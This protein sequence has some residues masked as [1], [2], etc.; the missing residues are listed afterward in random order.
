M[1]LA[2]DESAQSGISLLEEEQASKPAYMRLFQR[3]MTF[4]ASPKGITVG[5]GLVAILVLSLLLSKDY[6]VVHQLMDDEISSQTVY[7]PHEMAVLDEKETNRR[8]EQARESITP[9]Y[10]PEQ[11]LNQEIRAN[12]SQFFQQL[13][14]LA[15]QSALADATR[16][17]EFFNLTEQTPDAR[18]AYHFLF[19]S[20]RGA[21][22]VDAL[23]AIVRET[24]DRILAQGVTTS[25]YFDRRTELIQSALPKG[26]P[27]D[28]AVAAR[29]LVRQVI[30]PNRVL[31]EAAMRKAGSLAASKVQA[32]VRI[33]RKGEK[34]TDRGELITS[35]QS[36][37]LQQLGRSSQGINWLACLGVVMLT[38]IGIGTVWTALY[39][40]DNKA[41][42]KPSYAGMLLLIMVGTAVIFKVFHEKQEIFSPYALP[43]AAFAFTIAIFVQYRFAILATAVLVF[44]L[45]LTLKTDIDVLVMLMAGSLVGVFA[46]SRRVNTGERGEVMMAGV[47]AC[48]AQALL[49]AALN[50]LR[51]GS[52]GAG[53]SSGELLTLVGLGALG[54]ILSG[55]LTMGMLPYLETVF[56]L[57]TPYSI[58]ELGNH[59]KPLLKRMQFEAPGSLMIAS[60]AE[61]AAE[62]IGAN[63]LLARVGSLYHDIGKMKRPLFFIENQAYFGVENPHDKL[64]P[65]LSKM[66]VTAHPRDSLEMARQHGIPEVLQKFMTEHHG[67]LLAGYFYNKACME[68]GAENVNK[69]QFR[70]PGPKPNIKETAIVMLADAC[71]SA[72]RALKSPTPQQIEERIDKIIQQRIEDGQF[73]ECPI[74]FKEIK[75]VRD[76]FA[77]VLRGIQ[78]NRIEYQQ[79]VMR[80]LGRKIPQLDSA[81]LEAQVQAQA[82]EGET[83]SEKAKE[84]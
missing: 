45:G 67:T 48:L 57:V 31:D 62:A 37:A 5:L 29:F 20:G 6:W 18:A 47:Y 16:R 65:R 4:A 33:Y 34:I 83:S 43:M 25:D 42:F 53:A 64:T 54:G 22:R 69:S 80:E 19:Q 12:L 26:L 41:Y 46:L 63:P 11:R 71:E 30:K 60:L 72:V 56:R 68:E 14:A 17:E 73:D 38:A 1:K 51:S 24:V 27:A 28:E 78:H 59:D 10:K 66:V 13:H 49:I 84:A 74:T 35:V 8:R 82:Q 32:Q 50:L 9:I 77:R 61:S 52:A 7:A 15:Q 44:L 23:Q 39:Y 3:V 36:K 21:A 81:L 70:Y 55:A 79:N 75:I 40:V 2:S 58:M 76:T